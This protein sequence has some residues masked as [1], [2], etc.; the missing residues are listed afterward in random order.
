MAVQVLAR[1]S[2]PSKSL[3]A[4]DVA[5]AAILAKPGEV[6]GEAS[7]EV[8]CEVSGEVSCEASS[9]PERAAHWMSLETLGLLVLSFFCCMCLS[10]HT[11]WTVQ[12]HQKI[13]A[14]AWAINDGSGDPDV[15]RVHGHEGSQGVVRLRKGLQRVARS[16]LDINPTRG[17]LPKK[18]VDVKLAQVCSRGRIQHHD[19]AAFHAIL[20]ICITYLNTPGA[21]HR[22]LFL[23]GW[24]LPGL[25]GAYALMQEVLP[26]ATR[27]AFF[28]VLPHQGPGKCC[29]CTF[30]TAACDS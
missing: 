1:F 30:H 28:Q 6:S 26:N 12:G 2:K 22:R 10:L 29:P 23:P 17:Q 20:A 5:N 3:Q 9:R 24:L 27:K 25:V 7:G 4:C 13:L 16:Q 18:A 19:H 15:R 11:A 8:S 14:G 21:L